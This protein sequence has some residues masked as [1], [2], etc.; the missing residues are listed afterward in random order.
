MFGVV[1]G[2]PAAGVGFKEEVFDPEGVCGEENIFIVVDEERSLF[3]ELEH[4]LGASP[5]MD[6]FLR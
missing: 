3:I 2:D 6:L 4:S 5:E 1:A